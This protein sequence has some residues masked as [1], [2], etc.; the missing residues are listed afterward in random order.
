MRTWT[1]AD[2]PETDQ[3]GYWHEV[4]CEAFTTVGPAADSRKAFEN[5]V[6]PRDIGGVLISDS[7]S[8][9]QSIERGA[10]G[11]PVVFDGG[12]WNDRRII[13]PV[14]AELLRVDYPHRERATGDKF[15]GCHCSR[16][17]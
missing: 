4:I 16:V 7:K 13:H 11:V 10:C 8:K 5:S 3:F 2:L 14:A 15:G 17:G 1:T 6:T 12:P 9:A